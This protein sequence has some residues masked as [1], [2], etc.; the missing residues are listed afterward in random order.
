MLQWQDEPQWPHQ[1]MVS[2]TKSRK[3]GS[4]TLD[5]LFPFVLEI[6]S[7]YTKGRVENPADSNFIYF[8]EI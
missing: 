6:K 2:H 8:D 1:D 5:L 7:K 4:L 3:K